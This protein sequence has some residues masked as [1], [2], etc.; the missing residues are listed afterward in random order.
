MSG[1]TSGRWHGN[2]QSWEMWAASD[3]PFVLAPPSC[4]S[5]S[6]ILL[7]VRTL[8][9]F[10]SEVASVFSRTAS[11]EV[12]RG[13]PIQFHIRLASNLIVSAPWARGLCPTTALLIFLRSKLPKMYDSRA[14]LASVDRSGE[15]GNPSTLF[16]AVVGGKA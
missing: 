16:E 9:Q 2:F 14:V 6:L 3:S 15:Y 11:D 5:P 10:D 1:M 12:F 8:C 7:L 13:P 4:P